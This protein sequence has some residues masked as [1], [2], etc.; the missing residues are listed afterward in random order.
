VVEIESPLGFQLPRIR[1]DKGD[2]VTGGHK[3]RNHE[4]MRTVHLREDTWQR[5]RILGKVLKGRVLRGFR[6]QK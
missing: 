3:L 6:Y 2:R 4:T 1:V 5:F